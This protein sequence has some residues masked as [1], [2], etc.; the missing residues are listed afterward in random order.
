MIKAVIFD[1]FSVLA[2]RDS[3][4]FRET[5][6]PND[7]DKLRQTTQAQNELGLGEI[8]Y[9]DF[10]SKLAKIGGVNRQTALKYTENYH[11]NRQLLNFIKN[12]LKPKYKVGIV[13]NAGQ[14]WVLKIL[15]QS[16]KELFDDII[17]SYK[18]GAIKPEPKI[19]EL[20]ANNLGVHPQECIFVDDILTYC[21]GA[22][23]V[24][25]KT[26]WYKDFETACKDINNLLA[27]GSNN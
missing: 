19:Y 24:G 9:D 27:A 21:N 10:V 6:Y 4:S 26:V 5:F 3:A 11:A 23:A 14:D 18:V 1:F 15:G 16:G 22:E 20:A 7:P 25:M 2:I 8:G 13:S 12:E 17:L